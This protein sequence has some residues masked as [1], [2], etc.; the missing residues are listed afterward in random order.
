MHRL[1]RMDCLEIRRYTAGVIAAREE[2]AAHP[3]VAIEEDWC[4]K[5]C[6]PREERRCTICTAAVASR[7]GKREKRDAG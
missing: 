7:N 5:C 3:S 6:Y 2:Y 4:E 1:T